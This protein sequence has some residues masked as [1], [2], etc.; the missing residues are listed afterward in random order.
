VRVAQRD[1]SGAWAAPGELL[2]LAVFVYCVQVYKVTGY[3]EIC[4]RYGAEPVY[5]DEGPTVEVDL[6]D[7]T[8]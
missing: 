2:R 4:R 1:K 7:G 3:A 8:R 5:L 6:R